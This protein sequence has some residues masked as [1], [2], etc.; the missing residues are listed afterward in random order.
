MDTS[1]IKAASFQEAHKVF[2]ESA[3]RGQIDNLN[4][5]KQRIVTGML[6]PAG[7]GFVHDDWIKK[8]NKS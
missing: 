6:I 7:T 1:F 3:L 2:V 8:E 4:G 5:M